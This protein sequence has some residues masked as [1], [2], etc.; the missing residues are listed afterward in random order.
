MKKMYAV[1]P[2]NFVE[3]LIHKGYESIYQQLSD[4]SRE[5]ISLE[6]FTAF[7]EE[8]L[9]EKLQFMQ[10]S[11]MEIQGFTEYQWLSHEETLGLRVLFSED[12]IIYGFQIV[13]ARMAYPSDKLWSKN[14]YA[15]PFKGSWLTL[16]GGTNELVNY[17]YPLE[18]QRYA[19]DFVV[20]RNGYTF[21]GEP[22]QNENYFAF[23]K[24]IYAPC[25]GTVVQ[26]VSTEEDV[27][28]GI[29]TNEDQP[30][31]NYVIIKHDFDEYSLTCHMK[32]H[33]MMVKVGDVV[34]KGALLGQCGNSGH[35]TEPHI[36]FHVMNQQD[37]F[38][39][40]SIRIKRG[41]EP[42]RGEMVKNA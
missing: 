39:A 4:T 25:K 8:Q 40:Q 29:Q 31:G 6:A 34:E 9:N 21:D 41:D 1:T 19:Y 20:S 2:A 32:Q 30:F 12:H 35:T 28:P 14:T 26:C 5:Q 33:S 10:V 37:P 23:G 36:H 7:C 27:Q 3:V 13:P 18:Q 24:E 22:D 11:T 16:W 17:H 42:I 15:F 38:S